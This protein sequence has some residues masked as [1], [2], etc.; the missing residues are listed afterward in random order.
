MDSLA[1]KE[2]EVL[3]SE[4]AAKEEELE[5]QKY[6]F[7]HKLFAGMGERMVAHLK[8]PQKPDKKVGRAYRRALKQ[9]IKDNERQMKKQKKGGF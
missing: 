5:A 4:E 8:S 3:K 6:T 7:A 2:L 1:K 9:T